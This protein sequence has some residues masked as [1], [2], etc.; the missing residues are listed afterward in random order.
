M[1]GL[2]D[3]EIRVRVETIQITVLLRSVRILRSVLETW[4]DLQSLSLQWYTIG[5][6]WCK[7][8]RKREKIIL[9]RRPNLILINKKNNKKTSKNAPPQKKT[10][11]KRT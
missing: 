2:E 10:K 8:I 5:L 9:A 1:K 3:L 7:K 4:R 6:G 11:N